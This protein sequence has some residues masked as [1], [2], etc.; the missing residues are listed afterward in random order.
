MRR[1]TPPL[2]TFN[3]FSSDLIV[4]ALFFIS[5]FL[6]FYISLFLCPFFPFF[7]EH[8]KCLRCSPPFCCSLWEPAG[9]VA[10]GHTLEGCNHMLDIFM[11][12][13]RV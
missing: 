12:D 1:T 4:E 5:S 9:E 6:L 2:Y 11:K 8:P 7:P 3:S 10:S 13:V